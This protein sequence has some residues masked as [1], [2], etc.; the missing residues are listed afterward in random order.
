MI[1]IKRNKDNVECKMI[2]STAE[3]LAEFTLVVSTFK[4]QCKMD[5]KDIVNAL[6]MG[7]SIDDLSKE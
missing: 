3:L 6:L 7:L 1:T 5:N 4:H 2:G